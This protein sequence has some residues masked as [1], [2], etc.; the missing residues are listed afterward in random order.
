MTDP[1]I[2]VVDDE[3]NVVRLCQ[4]LLEKA[5]FQV[6]TA[7]SQSQALAIL[8]RQPID[9]LLLDIHMHGL[10]GFQL[11]HLAHNHQP[12]LA[13]IVMTNFGAVETAVEALRMG[14][15]GMVLKPF[16]SSELVESVQHAL[17]AKQRW[18][19]LERLSTLRPLFQITE[20]FFSETNLDQLKQR[21]V[22][23]VTNSLKCSMAGLYCFQADSGGYV[24]VAWHGERL[25]L[26]N[27]VRGLVQKLTDDTNIWINRV[28]LVQVENRELLE[29]YPLGSLLVV[30]VSRKFKRE[31]LI[32]ARHLDEPAFRGSDLEF[33]QML[34]R[35]A[36]IAMEKSRLYEELRS[37]INELEASRVAVNRAEKIAAAGRITASIAHE[38]NNPLQSI[39]NCLHLAGRQELPETERA[40]YLE[41]AQNELDRLIGTVHRTLD[42]YRPSARDRRLVDINELI[43]KVVRLMKPQLQAHLINMNCE[44]AQDLPLVPV[45][46]DQVQQLLI[47][48]I[49]NSMD[50]MSSGGVIDIK[51][52]RTVIDEGSGVEILVKDTGPGVSESDVEQI[53]EPFYT[54]KAHGTGLGLP[55]S[56]GIVAAH[57]GS[58]NYVRQE[59]EGAC[60]RIVFPEE[61]A[62]EGE[63]PGSR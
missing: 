13:S 62:H 33:L 9:L 21:I 61:I 24:Q 29:P 28:G 39:S 35:Q 48:L 20:E 47:N 6:L 3:P 41:L 59:G 43:S 15:E 58:L 63:N 31:L 10:D 32:A 34:G 60:F 49:L 52:N 16:A 42:L 25:P 30:P 8:A 26:E 7:N 55:V 50:A 23:A 1:I 11:L 53:F 56:Y 19:D 18:R 40:H 4:R 46:S 12:E 51:T 57:G 22:V 37:Y 2:L 38:L 17:Q 44:F 45:V 36:G 5:R 54:T 27:L 14:A